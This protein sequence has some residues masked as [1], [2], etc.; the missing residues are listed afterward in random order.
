MTKKNIKLEKEEYN[1]YVCEDLIELD[2]KGFKFKLRTEL[3]GEDMI[4]FAR[5][6]V[7]E[8]SKLDKPEQKDEGYSAT[9]CIVLSIREFPFKTVSGKTWTFADLPDK[10]KTIQSLKHEIYLP[11]AQTCMTNLGK[12]I[13]GDEELKKKLIPTI[14]SEKPGTLK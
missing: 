8:D 13:G 14:T 4:T 5:N 12:L 11:L 3:D 2:V 6:A 1:P 9:L 7:R 10:I